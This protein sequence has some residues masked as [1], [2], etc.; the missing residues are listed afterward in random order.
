QAFR[1]DLLHSNQ[2][3]YGAVKSR[4]PRIVVAH[5]DVISW[6]HARYGEEPQPTTWFERYRSL[7]QAG[8]QGADILVSP[9]S[10]QLK[11]L[12]RHYGSLDGRGRVV[13]NG[14]AP[15]P[16][17][18]RT[19]K[20]RAVTAGRLWDECKNTA[21]VELARVPLPVAVAGRDQ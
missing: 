14:S 12:E 3:Y 8:L 6:W 18:D 17:G 9:S 20:L 7:V 4:V 1:P 16:N 15:Q 10:A 21:I 11:S 5:S 19:R 13:F 2:Y